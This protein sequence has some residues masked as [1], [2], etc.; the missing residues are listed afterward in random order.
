MARF[1]FEFGGNHYR[2]VIGVDEVGRGS[3]FGPVTVGA[4]LVTQEAWQAVQQHDWFAGVTDSKMLSEKKRNAL[5]PLIRAELPHAVCHVAVRY[6]DTYNINRA[7]QNGIYRS[8]QR[9]LAQTKMN[10]AECRVIVD[11]NYRFEFPQLRMQK[12][13]PRLD[14]E[15]KADLKF[16]PVSAASIIAKVERDAMITRAASRFP[17][18]GLDRHAGYG[19]AAHRET[20]T[21][22]GRTKFHRQSFS[23]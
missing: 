6:I 11:G 10:P 4:T 23:M 19:T 20:I 5:A 3:L 16:F 2:A 15:I 7:V 14:A 18:Y 17:E 22:L 8:V 12:V 13:M 21:R 9:L 1:F